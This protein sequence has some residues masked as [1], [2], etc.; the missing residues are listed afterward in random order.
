MIFGDN[1]LPKRFWD[2]VQPEPNTGCWLWAAADD[3]RGRPF[4]RIDGVTTRAYKLTTELEHGPC[5][6][7]KE[8][9][10]L[11]DQKIC[12]NPDHII[13]ETTQQNNARKRGKPRLEDRTYPQYAHLPPAEYAKAVTRELSLAWYYRRKEAKCD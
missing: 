2:K 13:Y 3:G 8:C 11:C 7:G 1:R 6:A 10:H 12:V 4:F 9:S 5:P